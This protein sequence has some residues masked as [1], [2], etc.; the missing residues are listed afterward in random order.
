MMN[1]LIR[2]ENITAKIRIGILAEI[3]IA[4][5]KAEAELLKRAQPFL[6]H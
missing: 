2:S 3:E 5:I 1:N 6:K 4:V